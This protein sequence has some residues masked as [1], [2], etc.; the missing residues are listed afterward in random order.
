MMSVLKCLT[1][2][3]NGLN[4]NDKRKAIFM[5]LNSKK[6]DVILLQ[7]THSTESSYKVWSSQ[8][9][10]KSLWCHGLS[11]SRGVAILLRENLD[12]ELINS[13]YDTEGR[14]VIAQIRIESNVFTFCNVYAPVA[15]NHKFQ[16]T[17]LDKLIEVLNELEAPNVFIGGDFNTVLNED[18]DKRGNI[19]ERFNVRRSEYTDKLCQFAEDNDLVDVFRMLHEKVKRFTFRRGTYAARLDWWWVPDH[20]TNAIVKIDVLTSVQSD[21]S[22]VMFSLKFSEFERGPG[23]WKFNTSLLQDLAYIERIKKLCV[24]DEII[25]FGSNA[26]DRW[27]FFKFRAREVSIEYSKIKKSKEKVF[28]QSLEQHMRELMVLQDLGIGVEPELDTVRREI[29]ECE[30]AKARAAAFR[31]KALWADEGEKPTKYFLNLERNRSAGKAITVLRKEDGSLIT[32]REGIAQEQMDF[33]SKLYGTEGETDPEAWLE[34]ED[35]EDLP[36]ISEDMVKMLENP[37][38]VKEL[39]KA[40]GKMKNGKTPGTDGFPVEFYKAFWMDLKDL[41]YE[42]W[43][44]ALERG[45]IS[46]EQCRGI[47][48]LIPKKEKDRLTLANWRPITLLNVDFKIFTKCLAMRLVEALQEIIDGSQTGFMPGRYIG[49]NI[50]TTQDIIDYCNNYGLSS[51][52]LSV[53][54]LKAFDHLS[55][56]SV[57]MSLDLFGFSPKF[58]DYVK[59]IFKAPKTCI[60]NAGWYSDNISIKRGARQ[61]CTISPYLFILVIEI[62]NF[63]I[64]Q[65]PLI[66]GVRV[67]LDTFKV[68][69]YADD[70]TCYAKSGPDIEETVR[71]ITDFERF[72]GLRVNVNKTK[73][74][75]VGN[76]PDNVIEATGIMCQDTL[77]ILGTTLRARTDM[78]MLYNDNFKPCITKMENRIFLWKKRRLSLKGRITV[79]NTLI[80]SLIVFI[81]SVLPTPNRVFKEVNKMIREFI[82]CDKRDKIAYDNVIQEI[83]VG[84]LKLCD[85]RCKVKAAKIGWVKRLCND[86][87]SK[88]ARMLKHL[89]QWRRRTIALF[90]TRQLYCIKGNKQNFVFFNDMLRDWYTIHNYRIP[91][92]IVHDEIIWF[93]KFMQLSK[94]DAEKRELWAQRGIWRLSDVCSNGTIMSHLQITET[95]NVPCTFL[96]A[97]SIKRAMPKHWLRYIQENPEPQ[98]S[99]NDVIL[100]HRDPN[101]LGDMMDCQTNDFYWFFVKRKGRDVAGLLYWHDKYPEYFDT[102]PNPPVENL[103]YLAFK[104]VRETKYQSLQF[105]LLHRVIPCNQLLKQYRIITSSTCNWCSQKDDNAHFFLSCG[106]VAGLW[107]RVWRWLRYNRIIEGPNLT[108]AEILLGCFRGHNVKKRLIINT[109]CLYT[110]FYV[111]RQRLFHDNDCNYEGWFSELKARCLREKYIIRSHPKAGDSRVIDSLLEYM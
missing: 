47:L 92:N 77:D 74:L 1:Y 16:L 71:V 98:E 108:E 87:N 59:L 106:K 52:V 103:C 58:I 76:I 64:R 94:F 51:I 24:A 110:K 44:N 17:F 96:E 82:W 33:Y 57:Y 4:D 68:S 63:K 20:L 40:L 12:Y 34:G 56:K 21:H 79:A 48:C 80:I 91:E 97:M 111:H 72:S 60:L 19:A 10:G 13:V 36:K 43:M 35:L 104:C 30:R 46:Q 86:N 45:E 101:D 66:K 75:I 62:L 54:F 84:G 83:E 28:L 22:P 23:F 9:R 7:E 11:N 78:E 42:A 25:N 26:S 81:A 2:N 32:T 107:D 109:I 102:V 95:Y 5:D 39:G 88:Q 27:E 15:S 99:Q 90:Q 85:L 31:A 8:W 65:N 6:I 38:T 70:I 69:A 18:L 93:N 61:G 49:E 29:R 89:L 3:V 73:A 41:F 14:Y 105:K 100:I 67:G 55:W 50:R 53:D 37:I